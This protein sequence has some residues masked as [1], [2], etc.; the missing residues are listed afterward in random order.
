MPS[1][2][3]ISNTAGFEQRFKYFVFVQH[4]QGKRPGDRLAHGGLS[5][6]GDTAD[7]DVTLH[8]PRIRTH[9]SSSAPEVLQAA[10]SELVSPDFDF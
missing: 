3:C 2:V 9:N 4:F 1:P 7:Y 10:P 6:R 5:A 8:F